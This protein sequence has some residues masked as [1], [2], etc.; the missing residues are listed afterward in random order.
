M[1]GI[2]ITEPM[3][4]PPSDMPPPSSL[5]HPKFFLFP[6]KEGGGG[7][8]SW[9]QGGSSQQNFCFFFCSPPSLLR[10][11]YENVNL[12]SELSAQGSDDGETNHNPTER[13]REGGKPLPEGVLVQTGRASVVRAGR[14]KADR[15][16]EEETELEHKFECYQGGI[17]QL[18]T[19]GRGESKI[20]CKIMTLATAIHTLLFK[21]GG[22]SDSAQPSIESV[23]LT[24][25]PPPP[26]FVQFLFRLT[27]P[28]PPFIF[29]LSRQMSHCDMNRLLPRK[30]DGGGKGRGLS[31]KGGGWR[32]VDPVPPSFPYT[33]LFV[34][35][36]SFLGGSGGKTDCVA[37]RSGSREAKK[38]LVW[39]TQKGG[40]TCFPRGQRYSWSSF[41]IP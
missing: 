15:G 1:R 14:R 3:T 33:L 35:G 38:N 30:E 7:K 19:E 8:S 17:H 40:K 27:L 28:P 26:L 31:Q 5:S 18:A 41:C 34:A 12:R 10:R 20:M 25:I 22:D 13:K 29:L 4:E 21:I 39:T 32:R 11:S 2:R 23:R 9:C 37:V 24:F 36:F 16:M 6:G